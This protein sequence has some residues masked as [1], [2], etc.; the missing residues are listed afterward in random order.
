MPFQLH[1]TLTGKLQPLPRK[2]GGPLN[3]YLCG[4]TVYNF[5]HVG[6][7]RP[8]VVFDTLV[9]HLRASGV[10]VRFARNFTD[11]DDKIINAAAREGVDPRAHAQRFIDAY[12]EDTAALRCDRPNEEP[13][14]SGYIPQIV[15]MIEALLARGHAYTVEGDVYFDVRSDAD[16]GKLSRRS[17][18]EDDKERVEHDE[19]KRN[20]QDFAL[21]KSAKP[22]EPEG[23]RW[24][25]PWGEGR[26]GWHIECSAMCDGL[27]PEGVDIHAGGID[28]LFPHH[29]NEIAQ[30]ECATGHPFART[31]MHNAFVNFGGG[32]ISK[33]EMEKMPRR[34]ADLF[35]LRKLLE[36]YEGEA[37]RL[38]LLTQHYRNPIDLEMDLQK[39]ASG[40]VADARCPGIEEAERRVEYFYETRARLDARAATLKPALEGSRSTTAEAALALR[41][42][43]DAALDSDLDTP[44]ALAAAAGL[45]AQANEFCDRNRKDAVEARA[46]TEGLARACAVL[47]VGDGDAEALAARIKARRIAARNL[48]ASAIQG[49]VDA[50]IAARKS[51]DFARADELRKE[52]AGQGIELRD[53]PEGGSTWKVLP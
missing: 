10:S 8:A 6:N 4:P 34:V 31:W 32:K 14:V 29:E 52:L 28:L 24:P 36:R 41:K 1:D 49:K 30:S 46:L 44:G 16:Y 15:A 9:R 51:K 7:A 40:E 37:V 53:T 47:G 39:D 18:E 11:I 22:H 27:F 5:I 13:R 42:R 19:R 45:F 3:I 12:R 21:W 33:S 26:P 2:D 17:L 23:A 20:K 35:V 48:D 25:S 38:W 50:R 43:F